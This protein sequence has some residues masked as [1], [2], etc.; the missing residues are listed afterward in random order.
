MQSYYPVICCRSDGKAEVVAR[1]GSIEPNQPTDKQFNDTPDASGHVDCY[2]RL[3]DTA[4]KSLDWRRKLGGMIRDVLD[5]K[6][7]M[8]QVS[9]VTIAN[10]LQ[11]RTT[12]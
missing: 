7:S 3:D 12:Y 10:R 8:L 5:P 9:V 4:E 2:R 6:N 11:R 1:N